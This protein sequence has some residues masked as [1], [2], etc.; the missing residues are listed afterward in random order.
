MLK[1]HYFLAVQEKR[2][3]PTASLQRNLKFRAK[4]L[5]EIIT[6]KLQNQTK[7]SRTGDSV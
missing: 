6:K 7:N 5:N 4:K 1:Y 2:G 3:A